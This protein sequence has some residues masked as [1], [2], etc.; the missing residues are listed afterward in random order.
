[1]NGDANALANYFGLPGTVPQ[2]FAGQWY[3]HSSQRSELLSCLR[4]GDAEVGLQLIG[5]CPG[6]KGWADSSGVR[7]E[8]SE[9]L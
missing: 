6:C 9:C 1:M 4:S 5:H 2:Q 8:L 3:L 7:N